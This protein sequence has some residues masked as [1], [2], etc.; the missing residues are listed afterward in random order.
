MKRIFMVGYSTDK[1]GVE[2]YIVNLCNMLPESEYE[3]IYAWPEMNIN[4]KT[5][6]CPKNRHNY[7]K[8]RLF[9]KRFFKENPF[10][11]LYYNAC[12]IVSIDMLKFAKKAGV[13]VRIIHS[14]SAGNQMSIERE[15]SFF[16]KIT[17]K[18]NRKNIDQYATHLFACSKAAGDWMFSG[19]PFTIVKNG[20]HLSKFQYSETNRKQ[21]RAE[22][23]IDKEI[24]VGCI[25]RLE[26]QKNPLFA[27]K[28]FE[29]MNK[30]GVPIKLVFLGEGFMKDDIQEM[31]AEKELKNHVFFLGNREDVNEWMSAIDCLLMPSLFEGLPFVLVEAQA[32][33]LPC[34]VSSAVSEEAN[35]T[36]L[37]E[38]V[39]LEEQK[40][41]W[42]QKILTACKGRR[43]DT[44]RQLA[45]AG[46]SIEDTAKEVS[47][48]M[49]QA[50][51]E[52]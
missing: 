25:G 15:L 26:P 3:V 34:I 33:G 46:Y 49:K 47:G 29:K 28:V 19:H 40:E 24:V 18:A 39:S 6:V 17:E 27:V 31:L 36:G 14:H 21:H 12:D 1:G 41:V 38:Y 10:D 16:H 43:P 50:F 4:G 23:N 44:A 5:W 20:I 11:I 32:A 42:A 2:S 45:E 8:Y 13:L 22:L 51:G 48:I 37:V 35:I 30:T 7:L 52:T 9:W